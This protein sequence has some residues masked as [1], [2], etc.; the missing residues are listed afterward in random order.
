MNAGR[1]SISYSGGYFKDMKKRFLER[2]IVENRKREGNTI[3][4][5]LN[6]CESGL[7]NVSALRFLLVHVFSFF[8]A[9]LPAHFDNL[10]LTGFKKGFPDM[11][12]HCLIYLF[13]YHSTSSLF[14]TQNHYVRGF[15]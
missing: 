11:K 14:L 1:R 2:F 9:L 4:T 13:E 5:K 7:A 10:E 15:W 6:M 3:K 8:G 12:F